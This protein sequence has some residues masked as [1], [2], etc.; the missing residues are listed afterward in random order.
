MEVIIFDHV[1][2]IG[3]FFQ[4]ETVEASANVTPNVSSILHCSQNDTSATDLVFTLK[5]QTLPHLEEQDDFLSFT[6]KESFTISMIPEGLLNLRCKRK[7]LSVV[8]YY[9]QLGS[10]GNIFCINVTIETVKA[11]GEDLLK[12]RF[13]ESSIQ[14]INSGHK[15]FGDLY[16]YQHNDVTF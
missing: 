7:M 12:P 10:Y 6:Q 1:F 8:R 11:V 3:S 13:H 5:S 4:L 16:L 2:G 9:S 14:N 15:T